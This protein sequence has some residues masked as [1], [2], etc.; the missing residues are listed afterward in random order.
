M[1]KK[2]AEH[3]GIGDVIHGRRIR[4]IRAYTVPA[5]ILHASVAERH[6]EGLPGFLVDYVGGGGITIFAGDLVDDE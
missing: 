6:P 1:S 3:L 5:R 2:L 4:A